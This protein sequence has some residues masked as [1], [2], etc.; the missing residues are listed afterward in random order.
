MKLTYW[1]KIFVAA[2]ADFEEQKALEKAGFEWHPGPHAPWHDRLSCAAC[3]CDA[4]IGFFT[5]D[6]NK[7][8]HFDDFADEKA[9]KVFMA[10][11]DEYKR[12]AE[13]E[14]LDMSIE[15]PSTFSW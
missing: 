14:Y 10:E 4:P 1:K 8:L 9:K 13:E 7:A 2:P 5:A 11:N 3:E 12:V 6:T 15:V